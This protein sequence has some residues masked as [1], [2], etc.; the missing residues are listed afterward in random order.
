[1]TQI[2]SKILSIF[3]RDTGNEASRM[4]NMTDVGPIGP[5]EPAIGWND[6]CRYVRGD[7]TLQIRSH[8][9]QDHGAVTICV[10]T[11]K[12]GQP[13]TTAEHEEFSDPQMAIVWIGRY[14]ALIHEYGWQHERPRP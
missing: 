6:L 13:V 9:S 8:T 5:A 7:S 14:M 3:V 12:D 2:G 10:H 4:S 1:V 11:G